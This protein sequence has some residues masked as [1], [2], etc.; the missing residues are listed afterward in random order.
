MVEA[1]SVGISCPAFRKAL[2]YCAVLKMYCTVYS[3]L[4][5]F[6]FTKHIIIRLAYSTVCS[7]ST[8][9]G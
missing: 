3:V 8:N 7:E 9:R 6:M 4:Y 2:F 1:G 5:V